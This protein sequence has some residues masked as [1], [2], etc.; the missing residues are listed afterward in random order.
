MAVFK[1]G[2]EWGEK[3]AIINKFFSPAPITTL[4]WGLQHPDSVVFGAADGKVGTLLW[5]PKKRGNVHFSFEMHIIPQASPTPCCSF[6][7]AR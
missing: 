6:E 4:C 2:A 1:L 7:Q 5:A 3:K